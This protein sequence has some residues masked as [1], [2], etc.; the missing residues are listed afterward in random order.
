MRIPRYRDET[1]AFLEAL[2]I[3]MTQPVQ[4]A[5]EVIDQSTPFRP[6]VRDGALNS[7]PDVGFPRQHSA[8][9]DDFL[10]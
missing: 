5:G 1:I 9:V 3:A 7:I 8:S 2:L 10:Q 4:L 6:S